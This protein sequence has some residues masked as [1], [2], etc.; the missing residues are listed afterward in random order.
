MSYN[1]YIANLYPVMIKLTKNSISLITAN[2]Q[3]SI[4]VPIVVNFVVAKMYN[5]YRIEL[6]ILLCGTPDCVIYRL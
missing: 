1:N 3:L 2:P 4:N 5:E 6:R